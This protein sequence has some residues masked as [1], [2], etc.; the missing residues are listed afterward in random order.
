MTTENDTEKSFRAIVSGR[1]QMVMYRDFALR[2]ARIMGVEGSVRNLGDG[3]VEVIAFGKHE[4]LEAYL[5]YLKKGPILARVDEVGVQWG[6]QKKIS[7]GFSI[8]YG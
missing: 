4:T 3:T 6:G 5:A 7:N 8:I 1:V 2:K